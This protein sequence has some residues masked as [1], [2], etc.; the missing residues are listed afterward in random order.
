S[1]RIGPAARIAALAALGLGQQGVDALDNGVA[2][3]PEFDGGK[4]EDGAEHQRHS[5]HGNEGSEQR[6]L[7]DR[8]QH[9]YTSPLKPINA[10]DIN[11]AVIMPMAAPLK[12]CGTS[13]TA[14]RSRMAENSIST[15]EKPS[16]APNPYR[17][18]WKKLL[19]LAVFCRA[20]PSTAQLVVIRGRK[21]PSTR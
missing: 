15:R 10:R 19:S 5:H 9:G 16:A 21:T 13:A 20:T 2:L 7:E 6:L 4:A 14:R 12:G 17:D 18:E 1:A 8:C 11:P 3:N